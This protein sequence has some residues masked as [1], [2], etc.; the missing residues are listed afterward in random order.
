MAVRNVMSEK[1]LAT[2]DLL[3]RA[4]MQPA[5]AKVVVVLARGEEIVSAK[6][7]HLTELRQPE[8]SIAMRELVRR[9]W[10]KRRSI[11]KPGKG[12]PLNGYVLCVRFADIVAELDAVQKRRAQE[13]EH[14]MSRLRRIAKG[15]Q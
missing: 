15:R 9:K 1:E 14:T 4:G 13:I 2:A 11:R 7:E 5:V 3:K 10:A 6:I 12:R 8:V